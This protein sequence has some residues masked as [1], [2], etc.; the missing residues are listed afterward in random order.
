MAE[1]PG[2]RPAEPQDDRRRRRKESAK[3]TAPS[4]EPLWARRSR[5]SGRQRA[6]HAGRCSPGHAGRGQ[7]GWRG[8]MVGRGFRGGAW[9]RIGGR[10]PA[11][12]AC[13]GES[14]TGVEQRAE[15]VL[16]AAVLGQTRSLPDPTGVGPSCH[17]GAACL[18]L[19]RHTHRLPLP[20]RAP[21]LPAKRVDLPEGY[22]AHPRAQALQGAWRRA[23]TLCATREGLPGQ[24]SP[25]SSRHNPWA[26]AVPGAWLGVW[27]GVGSRVS[28]LAG[29]ALL[30]PSLSP[31]SH[32]L[33]TSSPSLSSFLCPSHSRSERPL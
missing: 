6:G 24:T 23:G 19:P 2:H 14:L 15:R 8:L 21:A 30:P 29:E 22:P 7:A 4:G 3:A 1:P 31:S 11:E 33:P 10:G 5:E 25:V 28:A 13:P 12:G 17:G 16:W 32:L 20:D 18:C 26:P 27:P 9:F